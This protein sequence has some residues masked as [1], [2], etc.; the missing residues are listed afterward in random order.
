MASNPLTGALRAAVATGAL[1]LLVA[2]AGRAQTVPLPDPAPAP[3]G[4]VN[5]VA[6]LA[7]LDGCWGGTVNQ[8]DFREQWSPL[9][10]GILLGFGSTVYQG[11][12]QSYEY[13]RIESRADGV[14]YVALPSGQK[15]AAFK[16]EAIAMDTQGDA[17]YTF[18]NPENDFPQR[19]V[20]RRGS[21]G[22]LYA[23]IDGKLKGEERQVIYPMRRIDCETGEFIRK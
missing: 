9:R 21:E 11:K 16:L 4:D 13:L 6:S 15:E 18:T 1:A 14:Y 5:S 10:G 7:W 2:G 3:G 12:P 8:R 22:W 19:I 17:I 20:Y 23:T